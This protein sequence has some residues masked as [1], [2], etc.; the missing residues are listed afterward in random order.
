M[1]STCGQKWLLD[2]KS[3]FAQVE[4]FVQRCKDLLEASNG[5]QLLEN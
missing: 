4:A 5:P 3:I 1:H 2:D